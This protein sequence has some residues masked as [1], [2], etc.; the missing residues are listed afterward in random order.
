MKDYITLEKD[1]DVPIITAIDI[2]R[3][4]LREIAATD[5]NLSQ[6]QRERLFRY[7]DILSKVSDYV[8][9]MQD[10]LYTL[11]ERCGE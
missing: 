6:K 3:D 10:D 9:A 11:E 4:A 1:V 5:A 7:A 8:A 2:V